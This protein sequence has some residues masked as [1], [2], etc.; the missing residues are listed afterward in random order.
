MNTEEIAQV[1]KELAALETAKKGLFRRQHYSTVRDALF[2]S[3]LPYTLEQEWRDDLGKY[4][5]NYRYRWT[6][7][8]NSEASLYIQE[9]DAGRYSYKSMW[10]AMDALEKVLMDYL[11]NLKAA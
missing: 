2:E 7:K 9:T 10:K 6:S 1:E 5:R 4:L 8:W 11:K 3:K